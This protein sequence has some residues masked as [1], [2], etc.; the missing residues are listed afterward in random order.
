ME[1]LPAVAAWAASYV[2]RF[3]SVAE[4]AFGQRS[5]SRAAIDVQELASRL[6][7]KAQ[8]LVAGDKGFDETSG[9]WNIFDQPKPGVVVIPGAALDVAATGGIEI[10]MSSLSSVELSKDGQTAK[11]GG[12]TLSKAIIDALWQS[13]KQTGKQLHKPFLLSLL[14]M[15]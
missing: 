7:S 11:I 15:R 10:V 9:R 5:C 6:S 1:V 4:N 3:P 14:G 13:G 2:Y 8:V 12:G